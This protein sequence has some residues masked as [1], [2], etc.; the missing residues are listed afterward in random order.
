MDK[1]Q[2]HKHQMLTEGKLD[3]IGVRLEHA[4][5]KSLKHVAQ[6]TRVKA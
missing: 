4:P 5:M 1:K 3:D 2:K 6:G